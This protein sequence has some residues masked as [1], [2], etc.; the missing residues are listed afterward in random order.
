MRSMQDRLKQIEQLKGWTIHNRP[1]EKLIDV[2]GLN[3]Q[4]TIFY[5]KRDALQELSTYVH[6]FSAIDSWIKSAAVDGK[7]G[8][9]YLHRWKLLI[10]QI[11]A[12]CRYAE[13]LVEEQ[14]GVEIVFAQLIMQVT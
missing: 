14:F 13:T 6:E 2:D 11:E 7:N 3:G 9:S 5:P 4:F 10:E 12:T 1:I 8:G